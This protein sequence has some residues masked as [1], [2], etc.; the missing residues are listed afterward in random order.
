[1]SE[2]ISLIYETIGFIDLDFRSLSYL[3]SSSMVLFSFCIVF[4]VPVL[5]L[6]I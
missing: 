2:I 5:N 1:M 4:V 6:N 3:L